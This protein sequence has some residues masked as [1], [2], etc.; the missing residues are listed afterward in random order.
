M[1]FETLMILVAFSYQWCFFQLLPTSAWVCKAIESTSLTSCRSFLCTWCLAH[2]SG[3]LHTFHISSC[4]LLCRLNSPGRVIC[5]TRVT[6]W[7]VHLGYRVPWKIHSSAAR[8]N[9]RVF[10]SFRL[11]WWCFGAGMEA[12]WSCCSSKR[13][14]NGRWR[15]YSPGD[16]THRRSLWRACTYQ[17][18]LWKACWCRTHRCRRQSYE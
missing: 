14:I 11:S 2:Q 18:L 4:C 1:Q 5:L 12:L 17:P 3:R 7:T 13:M 9:T 16:S 8:L 15:G 6:T 10:G